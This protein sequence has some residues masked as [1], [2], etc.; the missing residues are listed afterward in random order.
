MEGNIMELDPAE[1][2]ERRNRVAEWTVEVMAQQL[3]SIVDL[4]KTQG[5]QPDSESVIKTLEQNSLSTKPDDITVIDEVAECIKLPDYSANGKK[6][7]K[8][9][10][11]EINLDTQVMEEL[12]SFVQTIASLYNENPFHNF[13]HANHVVMSVNKLLSRINAPDLDVDAN[14]KMLY[15]HTYGITSDPLTWYVMLHLH[16]LFCIPIWLFV[17]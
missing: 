13:D 17:N 7:S 12:R 6:T 4:R 15:D 10:V 8:S 14:G 2:L 11:S 3:K 5:V 16:E 1:V 9:D